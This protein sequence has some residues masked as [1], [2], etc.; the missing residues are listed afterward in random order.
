MCSPPLLS[1]FY[2]RDERA[3]DAV[4]QSFRKVLRG[5]RGLSWPSLHEAPHDGSQKGG[6]E[7]DPSVGGSLIRRL[8]SCF[9]NRQLIMEGPSEPRVNPPQSTKITVILSAINHRSAAFQTLYSGAEQNNFESILLLF[10]SRAVLTRRLAQKQTL[11]LLSCLFLCS[12]LSDLWMP[13]CVSSRKLV[14]VA[15]TDFPVCWM[16]GFI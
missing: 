11:P 8:V 5:V 1:R 12:D 16:E 4:K 13:V 9:C 6:N 15:S 10:C 14:L 7:R 2:C 3:A